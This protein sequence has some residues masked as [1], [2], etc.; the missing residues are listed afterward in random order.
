[1]IIRNWSRH[2]KSFM[3]FSGK[4]PEAM[5]SWLKKSRNQT[6][7]HKN[8]KTK[9]RVYTRR[10]VTPTPWNTHNWCTFSGLFFKNFDTNCS[11]S[12]ILIGSHRLWGENDGK[13]IFFSGKLVKIRWKPL[14]FGFFAGNLEIL[15]IL[16]AFF[17]IWYFFRQE[18]IQKS[19]NL[20][21]SLDFSF[22]GEKNM[23]FYDF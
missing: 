10:P 20:E 11:F 2:H 1:M 5:C 19:Q 18:I 12:A 3:F 16:A 9:I 15:L 17:I 23:F 4:K 22:F 7:K 8:Q 13:N 14:F 21:F 6:K